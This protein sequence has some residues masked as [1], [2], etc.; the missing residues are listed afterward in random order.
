MRG[1]PGGGR[2]PRAPR[3]RGHRPERRRAS[4][5]CWRRRPGW[6]HVPVLD[7]QAF[8]PDRDEAWSL[9]GR[10][11]RQAWRLAGPAGNAAAWPGSQRPCQPGTGPGGTGRYCARASATSEDNRAFALQGAV[12]LSRPPRG[13]AAWSLVDDLQWADPTSRDPA[14]PAAAPRRPR[15]H[16]GGIPARRGGGTRLCPRDL[17]HAGRAMSSSGRCPLTRSV[18]CSATRCW[19]R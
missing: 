12:R 3:D 1:D 2:R 16:G 10:L 5:G 4:P 18:P 8:A 9:A 11:L 7:V 13:R 17:W 6:S 14:G 15:Q 19:P